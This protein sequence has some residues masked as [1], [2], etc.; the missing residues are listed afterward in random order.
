MRME[1]GKSVFVF[2][3][4]ESPPLVCGS[5]RK[6]SREVEGEMLVC[7]WC[8]K[9]FHMKCMGTKQKPEG[10]WRCFGC[11]FAGSNAGGSGSGSSSNAERAIGGGSGSSSNAERARGGGAERMLDMNAPPPEEE[12]VQFLGARS[13]GGDSFG[14]QNQTQQSDRRYMLNMVVNLI[15]WTCFLTVIMLKVIKVWFI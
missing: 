4:N 10:E 7:V 13:A 11:L 9:C 1:S 3:L 8:G 15:V 2:D 14:M 5:C 6:L 12:E